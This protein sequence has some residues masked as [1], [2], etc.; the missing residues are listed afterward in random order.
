[1]RRA[2]GLRLVVICLVSL[3]PHSQ[4]GPRQQLLPAPS[5]ILPF[6]TQLLSPFVA[7]CF[8]RPTLALLALLRRNERQLVQ[9]AGAARQPADVHHWERR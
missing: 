2:G 1:M 3:C 5:L 4:R 8:L 7:G 9:L 6:L